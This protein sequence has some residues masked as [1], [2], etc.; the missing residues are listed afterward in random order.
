MKRSTLATLYVAA[1]LFAPPFLGGFSDASDADSPPNG[2][3]FHV[4]SAGDDNWSGSL[5]E[6][7]SDRTDGPL[8]S[9][10]GARD[11]IRRVRQ[12]GQKSQPITVRVRG[13]RYYLDAPFVLEPV[14][15]GT[16]KAPVV[17]EAH[18]DERPV[19]SG[20]RVIGGFRSK[21]PLW[22]TVVPQVKA[23]RWY[24]RQLFVDGRRRQPARGPNT[25]YHRIAGLIPGE[26]DPRAKPIA[27]DR[28]VFA[29]GDL[30]TW[31][32][33]R[34]V[35]IVLMHSWETSIHPLRSVDTESRIVRFAAPL[36]EWWSIGYWEEAQRYYV[37]N[38]Y[39]L[40]DRPGEWYLNRQT[41]VLTYWPMPGETIQDA[42]VVA[43]LAT[44]LVRLAGNADDGRYVEHVTLRGLA[45]QHA[46]WKLSPKGNS[47][48]Q[49]AVEVPAAIMAD[50]ARNCT[51]EDCQVAHVGTYGIWFRR[52]CKDC[53]VG[54]NRLFDLGAGGIRVGEAAMASTDEAESSR[55]LVDNNHIFDGGH[56]YAAGVGI[57]VA[58][59]SHNRISHNDIHDLLYSGISVGWNWNTAKNRTHHNL[60]EFN[61][62]H[63]LVHGV[64]SDAGLIYCLGVS[65]GSVIRNNVFHDIWPYSAPSFGWGI[66]LDAQCG[67]Y[68]VEN[69]LVFNTRSGGLMFNNGGHAHVIRNNVFALSADHALWPY[70]EKRP[71]TFQRNIVYL[72]QGELLIPH[73][74][75]SLDERLAAKEPLGLWD[76]NIYWHTGGPDKLR[77]YRRSFDEWQSLGL[78]RGSR[79]ADPL[80]ADAGGHDFRLHPDSPALKLGFIPVDISRVGLY[81]DP[82]WTSEATHAR[83]PKTPLPPPPEPPK[84]LEVDDDFETTPAG[85]H[86]ADAHVSGEEQGAS[87]AVSDVRA[88]SGKRSLRV[89]D[90]KTLQ[91][92]W[93][94]HFYYE[95]HLTEGIVRHAFDV[96]LTPNVE[97]FTEWRDAVAYPQNVGPSV[98]FHGDGRVTV[99][100]RPITTLP[101]DG[102]IHVEIEAR[103][104]NDAPGVFKLTLIPP[105]ETARV[106][107]NLAISGTRFN[108]VHWLGFSSTATA[109]AAFFLDNLEIKVSSGR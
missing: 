54:R 77:F 89:A 108:E 4:S 96:W 66:Y 14:D 25:G 26:P 84:R 31:S 7:N 50:G 3:C 94:P 35:N 53:T 11:A 98:G 30:E 39:E 81:G 61:H 6:P 13:G 83:C 28:F 72:S 88:A 22:E 40:L 99:A 71:S 59:S 92:S 97:F 82:A 45:F 70:S 19:F 46:D 69:N 75:R 34:D 103:L 16:A 79:V 41:G 48:T 5:P 36:K 17:F 27:R 2:A 68:L 21:G 76:G 101:V 80:F 42:E 10:T 63:D 100:G 38:A 106:F 85:S 67:N 52:G 87:I 49:A 33:P 57:W 20:G 58:Q 55:I 95:P 24:F 18:A 90:A 105:G 78:D 56:V 51:V 102:W 86:P 43:P 44:E 12:A 23:G 93:Q 47:S 1:I 9:L 73:G 74:E 60:I 8:A 62:V 91:P 107:G 32:R 65:P 109:D 104:G 29:P 15:S 64:L 37:E